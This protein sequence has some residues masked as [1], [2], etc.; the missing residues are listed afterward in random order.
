MIMKACKSWYCWN[1]QRLLN[2]LNHNKITFCHSLFLLI[3]NIVNHSVSPLPI[4]RRNDA[5]SIQ[6]ISNTLGLNLFNALG[7]NGSWKDHMDRIMLQVL[8]L[9]FNCCSFLIHFAF[10]VSSILRLHVF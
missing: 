2:L 3:C 8:D 4:K 5:D 1:W 10:H 6:L 9:V 7:V